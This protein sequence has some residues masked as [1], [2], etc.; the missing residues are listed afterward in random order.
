[1]N[2]RISDRRVNTTYMASQNIVTITDANWDEEV[3]KS[4]VPVLVDFWAEWCG[5]CKMLAPVLEE[6][7]TEYAGK[8]KVAKLN[9]EESQALANQFRITSIPTVLLFKNGQPTEQIVGLRSKSQY[10]AAIDKAAV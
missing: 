7:A 5:P 9:I 8:A 4:T 2:F 3:L 10:K 1:N 6:L